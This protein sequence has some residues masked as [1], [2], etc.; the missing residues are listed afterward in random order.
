VSKSGTAADTIRSSISEC[1]AHIRRLHRSRRLL[2]DTFP[3]RTEHI[4]SGDES[5]ERTVERLDQLVYRFMKLQDSMARRLLPA[6]YS[7]IERSDD[8]I[9]FIDLLNRFEALGLIPSVATWERFRAL[10]NNLTHD[11]PESTSQTVDTLNALYTE[12]PSFIGI[13]DTLAN[14]FEKREQSETV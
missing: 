8:T 10:R 1:R 3:F 12:L 4:T 14:A 7:Y 6:L 9:P 2:S 5:G 11:Y 13:F